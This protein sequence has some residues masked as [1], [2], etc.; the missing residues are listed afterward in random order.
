MAKNFEIS[1]PTPTESI[2]A[3]GGTFPDDEL[4]TSSNGTLDST[5][6]YRSRIDPV[7]GSYIRQE[8]V[9]DGVNVAYRAE[10]VGNLGIES[11][12]NTLE[13]G[14]DLAVR[15]RFRV[16]ELVL[17]K[18]GQQLLLFQIHHATT[19]GT[20]PGPEFS[21]Y[22]DA[23]GYTASALRS[24]DDPYVDTAARVNTAKCGGFSLG[25]VEDWV[26]VFRIREVGSAD[27]ANSEITIRRNSLLRGKFIGYPT[28]YAQSP[29]R[30]YLKF[31]P[32]LPS[33]N[34]AAQAVG[35]RA[36]VDTFEFSVGDTES[37]VYP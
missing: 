4:V 14:A 10:L 26:F 29:K 2:F 8:V 15:Y 34:S 17:P 22:L 11:Q 20:L 30:A 18:V 24:Y 5:I 35:N 7:H 19:G 27:L 9:A 6:F 28:I 12:L 33:W 37:D 16:N 23:N 21:V 1:F 13:E 3:D 25:A 36:I 31:G 32:Y